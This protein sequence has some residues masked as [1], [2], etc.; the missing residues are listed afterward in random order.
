M[1]RPGHEL[2]D[3]DA[4]S[5]TTPHRVALHRF[6]CRRADLGLH[7]PIRSARVLLAAAR[8]L[9]IQRRLPALDAAPND[10]RCVDRIVVLGRGLLER[11]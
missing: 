1:Y 3:C 6:P 5:S 4:D 9:A 2:A 11:K 10:S 7:R 8:G